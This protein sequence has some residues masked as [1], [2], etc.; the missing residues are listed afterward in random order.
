VDDEGSTPATPNVILPAKQLSAV[1]CCHCCGAYGVIVREFPRRG[2]G[3]RSS[4]NKSPS[5]YSFRRSH[6]D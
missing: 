3:R 4:I 5:K 2:Y 6:Y 1:G